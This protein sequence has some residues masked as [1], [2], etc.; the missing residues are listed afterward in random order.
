MHKEV[1]SYWANN[2]RG[3]LC[4]AELDGERGNDEAAESAVVF[5][6]FGADKTGIGAWQV[7]VGLLVILSI[8]VLPEGQTLRV[9]HLGLALR[10]RLRESRD[11][12]F[13]ASA[14]STCA[15]LF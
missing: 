4:G 6:G 3:I 9:G 5:V 12:R 13:A 11:N 10:D 8:A 2:G 15:I 1:K 7:S 14:G